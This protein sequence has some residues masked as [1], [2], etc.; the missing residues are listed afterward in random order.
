MV[1]LASPQ[2]TIGHA[3]L[4]A[5]L[6]K[7]P[8]YQHKDHTKTMIGAASMND[9]DSNAAVDKVIEEP[10]PECDA[11]ASSKKRA[12]G[13]ESLST[14]SYEPDMKPDILALKRKII[15]NIMNEAKAADVDSDTLDAL[16]KM[17]QAHDEFKVKM[18][19]LEK[20]LDNTKHDLQV[21]KNFFK[22][23][24]SG[25]G[26]ESWWFWD[27]QREARGEESVG[28]YSPDDPE[29]PYDILKSV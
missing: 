7:S 20:K 27:A 4:A 1:G 29:H 12:R 2:H 14:V 23:A 22:Y 17:L 24:S 26:Y 11:G 8:I 18:T 10:K 3:T 5:H 19:D 21:M 16:S 9:G 28:Q 15:E 25:N 13:D 6:Q